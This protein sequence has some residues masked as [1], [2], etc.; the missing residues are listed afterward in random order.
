[1]TNEEL[2]EIALDENLLLKAKVAYLE[3]AISDHRQE[4]FYGRR[5]C[6]V[7]LWKNTLEKEP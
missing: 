6:D 7:E 2:L 4:G 5:K 1:M 3:E